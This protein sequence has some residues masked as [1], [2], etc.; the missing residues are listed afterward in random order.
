MQ[1]STDGF[2]CFL[3]D[4]RGAQLRAAQA[5]ADSVTT[6]LRLSR[7]LLSRRRAVN[8]SG[9]DLVV[10]R[11]CASTLD[12]PPEQG[13]QMRLRPARRCRP[14]FRSAPA[15]LTGRVPPPPAKG[16]AMTATSL[17]TALAALAAVLALVLLA[18]RLARFRF[19]PR[20]AGGGGRMVLV[21]ALALD[22][23]RRLHLVRCDGR[24]VL[25]LTGGAAD[26]V[27]GWLDAPPT[28]PMS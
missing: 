17:L 3:P 8:L 24:H 11:L 13:R 28:G 7:V 22:P 15:L 12:L 20:L 25:L 18:G 6:T 16:R 10:G 9:L 1:T 14:A 19:A 23:R 4:D 26:Q 5:L 21:Q 2:P 27:V